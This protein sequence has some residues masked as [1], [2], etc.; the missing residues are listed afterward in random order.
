MNSLTNVYSRPNTLG[1]DLHGHDWKLYDCAIPTFPEIRDFVG[2]LHKRMKAA[3]VDANVRSSYTPLPENSYERNGP[4]GGAHRRN[5]NAIDPQTGELLRTEAQL[6]E[7]EKS[8]SS[9]Q[10]R[11][12][13][14]KNGLNVKKSLRILSGN[15]EGD[16]SNSLTLDEIA[17]MPEAQLRKRILETGEEV[18]DKSSRSAAGPTISANEEGRE[19][20]LDDRTPDRR[21]K[22][23]LLANMHEFVFGSS[24][25]RTSKRR[26]QQSTSATSASK[27][28]RRDLFEAVTNSPE[29]KRKKLELVSEHDSLWP[30]KHSAA[31]ASIAS[32]F[33]A[34]MPFKNQEDENLSWVDSTALYEEEHNLFSDD[35]GDKALRKLLNQP[36]NKNPAE[37]RAEEIKRLVA[38]NDRLYDEKRTQAKQHASTSSRPSTH[39]ENSVGGRQLSNSDRAWW[40]YDETGAKKAT[41]TLSAVESRRH[42]KA[43]RLSEERGKRDEK[44]QYLNSMK[45]KKEEKKNGEK[46]SAKRELA[47]KSED[48]SYN[49]PSLAYRNPGSYAFGTI[50][51]KS[52]SRA[53][54][55]R[56]RSLEE[57]ERFE[58]DESK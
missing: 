4:S 43:A 30:T 12:L 41:S 52:C 33:Q 5:L 50:K 40:H 51:K 6:T 46:S 56:R 17:R 36:K 32:Y 7:K 25:S 19:D 27:H 48:G 54:R 20:Y 16:A 49:I 28:F 22:T 57:M 55:V 1:K 13:L 11:K 14:R 3:G 10:L 38:E 18:R 15:Q 58:A 26:T 44:L 53:L 24:S 31:G 9:Y 42:Q 37:S 23:G 34:L 35:E 8:A 29:M 47:P 45:T 21:T 39:A 2:T